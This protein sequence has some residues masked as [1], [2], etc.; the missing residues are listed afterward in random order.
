[1]AKRERTWECEHEMQ[2]KQYITGRKFSTESSQPSMDDIYDKTFKYLYDGAKKPID[3]PSPSSMTMEYEDEEMV[4]GTSEDDTQPLDDIQPMH[5]VHQA[6]ENTQ[7]PDSGFMDSD[8][9]CCLPDHKVLCGIENQEPNN[10]LYM[11]DVTC[12]CKS[13]KQTTL[14]Q[15]WLSKKGQELKIQEGIMSPTHKI[16]GTGPKEMWP[17]SCFSQR[18]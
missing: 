16:K 15:F 8:G 13:V 1:M 5:D 4:L 2:K 6:E 18:F 7:Y 10:N 3:T 9:S 14:E 17:Q 12:N 11:G